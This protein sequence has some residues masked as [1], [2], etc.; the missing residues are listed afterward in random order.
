MELLIK[1]SLTKMAI[2]GKEEEKGKSSMS[3][4]SCN[5]LGLTKFQVEMRIWDQTKD[6]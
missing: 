1:I 6:Q 3:I 5:F 2:E 4:S